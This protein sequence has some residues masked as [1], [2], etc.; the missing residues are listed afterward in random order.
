MMHWPGAQAALCP[1]WKIVISALFWPSSQAHSSEITFCCFSSENLSPFS[2]I[3]LF[4]CLACLGVCFLWTHVS[5][6]FSAVHSVWYCLCRGHL[7]LFLNS[8]QTKCIRI[9]RE[10][11]FLC[12]LLKRVRRHP[13]SVGGFPLLSNATQRNINGSFHAMRE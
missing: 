13:H 6:H 8:Y 7:S 5:T 12:L 10:P 9:K 1:C 4:D 2:I 3:R 11:K